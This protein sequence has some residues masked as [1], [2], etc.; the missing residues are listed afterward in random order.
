[1]SRQ[2]TR[3]R[4]SVK[5]GT[6]SPN[7]W[8][9]TLSG[10]NGWPYT[11]GTRTEDKAPQGCDLSAGSSAGM[12][13]GG[14]DVEAALNSNSDPSNLT[15]CGPKL[16]LTKGSTLNAQT[17]NTYTA[18]QYLTESSHALGHY[19]G[20]INHDPRTTPHPSSAPPTQRSWDPRRFAPIRC[21]GSSRNPVRLHPGMAFTFS[22]IRTRDGSPDYRG[23]TYRA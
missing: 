21:S 15:Y 20:T 14:S 13:T 3:K 9:L 19:T 23:R 18:N 17:C 10:Q 7:P 2:S 16:V 1:M 6:P 8:D 12:A 4:A 5:S 22:G 11:E